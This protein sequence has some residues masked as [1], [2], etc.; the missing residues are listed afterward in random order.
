[1]VNLW[2]IWISMDKSMVDLWI[3]VP[4]SFFFLWD[5]QHGLFMLENLMNM[6]DLGVPPFNEK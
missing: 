5:P 4:R 1:M 3:F 6:D 2:L